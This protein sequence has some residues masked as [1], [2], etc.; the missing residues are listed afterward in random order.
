[1]EPVLLSTEYIV[2]I[3]TDSVAY[4]F[5]E[6]LC[7]YC[8]GTIDE[9][10]HAQDMADLYYLD[11]NIEDDDSINGFFADQKNPFYNFVGQHLNEENF[12]SPCSVWLNKNYGCNSSGDFALLTEN[13]CEKFNFP[14][15]FSIG[16]FFEIEPTVDLI[17]LLK[18][19]AI[20]FF[21]EI[22]PLSKKDKLVKIEGFRMIIHKK[23]GEEVIL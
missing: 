19:R 3:D 14:A 10:G 11:Q 16:I 2:V 5:V 22:L 21:E 9:K 6:K 18:S 13:N 4:E 7:S 12:Y 23:Y 17:Q 1:M 20:K 8:T 15:P